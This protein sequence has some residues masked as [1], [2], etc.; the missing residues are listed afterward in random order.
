M[1]KF[2]GK[3]VNALQTLNAHTKDVTC[4]EFWGNALLVTGSRYIDFFVCLIGDVSNSESLS[5]IAVIRQSRY[6]S[7]LLGQD[8]PKTKSF[9]R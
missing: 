4:L 9:H 2:F 8:S 6:G 3:N 7:G 1:S 5:L